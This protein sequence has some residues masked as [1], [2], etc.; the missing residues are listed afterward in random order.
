MHGNSPHN[1]AL[2]QLTSSIEFIF[3]IIYTDC[4]PPLWALAGQ[5]SFTPPLHFWSHSCKEE[6]LESNFNEQDWNVTIMKTETTPGQLNKPDDS[7]GSVGT[8]NHL[9][10]TIN[11]NRSGNNGTRRQSQAVNKG[12]TTD[13]Y[14]CVTQNCAWIERDFRRRIDLS[15]ELNAVVPLVLLTEWPLVNFAIM[16]HLF[17]H[18]TFIEAEQSKITEPSSERFSHQ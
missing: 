6:N 8:S 7:C 3:L 4:A 12:C 13:R 5:D 18:D 17:G 9:R 14:N 1:E 2:A 16:I 11:I 15:T 10:P